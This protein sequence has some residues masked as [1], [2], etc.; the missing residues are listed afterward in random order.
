MASKYNK[1]DMIAAINL[2]FL[3]RCL[4]TLSYYVVLLHFL[5]RC[6]TTLSYYVVLL[7][8]LTTLSYYVVKNGFRI[9]YINKLTKLQLEAIII[10][11]DMNIDELM[12]ELAEQ[13]EAEMIARHKGKIQMLSYKLKNTMNIVIHR[14]PIYNFYKK[15]ESI[16]LHNNCYIHIFITNVYKFCFMDNNNNKFISFV[17]YNNDVKKCKFYSWKG[18][19]RNFRNN[20]N[21]SYNIFN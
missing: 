19:I 21:N 1:Y 7:R 10:K 4:T 15:I 8:C 2:H 18:I 16:F 5:L 9:S 11:Y 3:L 6:L 13:R 20:C 14:N 17:N 12:F